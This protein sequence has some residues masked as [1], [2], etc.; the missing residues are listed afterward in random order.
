MEKK[1][2][3]VYFHGKLAKDFGKGEFEVVGIHLKDIFSGLVSRF[4][5]GFQD[6]IINGSWHITA[7]KLISKKLT[8]DDNFLSEELV[9]FPIDSEEL[10]VFPAILG[11]GGKGIGQIILGVVLIVIA[12]VVFIFAPPAGAAIAGAGAGA[13]AA[14]GLVTVGTAVSLGLAGVMSL[15]GGVMAMLTKS[16]SMGDYAS[17]SPV[18]QRASFLYNGAVNNTEQ[19]VPVPLVYGRHLTGSTVISAGMDVEQI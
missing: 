15:A 10:H 13:G 3:K 12:V 9:D 16:P 19:G 5:Q 4:G 17:A 18:D 14:G 2:Y 7:G 6:T 8:P 1:L 11:A